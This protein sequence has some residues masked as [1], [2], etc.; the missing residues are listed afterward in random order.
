MVGLAFR[1][2]TVQRGFK[3]YLCTDVVFGDVRL[4]ARIGRAAHDFAVTR[5]FAPDRAEFLGLL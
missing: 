3:V 2:Y 5:Y 1:Y 4:R